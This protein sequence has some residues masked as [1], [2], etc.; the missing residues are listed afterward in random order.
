MTDATPEVTSVV[1]V[2][3]CVEEVDEADDKVFGEA[4]SEEKARRST[5]DALVEWA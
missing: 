4:M 3:A 5:E 1:R 2:L